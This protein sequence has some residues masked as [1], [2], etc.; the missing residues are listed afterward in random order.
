MA[1]LVNRWRYGYAFAQ[2]RPLD[3][4]GSLG[5]RPILLLHGTADRIIP[6]DHAMRLAAE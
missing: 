2:V 4:I 5:P 3:L 1:D 6:D